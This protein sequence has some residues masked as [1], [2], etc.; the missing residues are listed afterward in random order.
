MWWIDAFQP[1][2]PTLWPNYVTN[3]AGGATL[4]GEFPAATRPLPATL[5]LP[6]G[7]ERVEIRDGHVTKIA[8]SFE[9]LG[10]ALGQLQV[11]AFPFLARL[12]LSQNQ[13]CGTG[14]DVRRHFRCE[15]SINIIFQFYVILHI[16]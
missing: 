16:S 1:D 13:L 3:E 15:V 9:K 10:V 8:L 12:F 7:L 4:S 2:E 14:T 11:A 6:P 5:D